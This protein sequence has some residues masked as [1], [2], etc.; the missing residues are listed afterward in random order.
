MSESALPSFDRYAMREW[1]GVSTSERNIEVQRRAIEAFNARDIEA[2]IA[3]ADPRV[4]GHS[5][6]AA[7][8]GAV[9]HGHD[10]LRR[11]HRDL[12]EAWGNEIRIEPEAYFA[13][14]EHTL[15]LWVFHG[16]G[17]HSGVEVTMPA[18]LVARWR[19]GLCV[20]FKGYA[21]REDAFADLGVTEDA[22]E[23]IAP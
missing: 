13:L 4:E 19:D 16:R 14:G 15:V 1:D 17:Q 5:T 9:Y 11:W 2:F 23:P 22:L 18:A 8:S 3:V 20:Y 12:E 7:V 21:N 6:F 10:G